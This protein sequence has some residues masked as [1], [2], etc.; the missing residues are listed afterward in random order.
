MFDNLVIAL[1]NEFFYHDYF[2]NIEE[3]DAR[4]RL[5]EGDR[6]GYAN[7]YGIWDLR[8]ALNEC[9]EFAMAAE[10]EAV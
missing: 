2:A 5:D 3:I 7:A 8:D 4:Y 10:Q 9:E 1:V 6:A